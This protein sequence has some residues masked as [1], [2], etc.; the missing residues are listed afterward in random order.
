MPTGTNL[1]VG[2]KISVLSSSMILPS[3][4][5]LN[6]I[7]LYAVIQVTVPYLDRVIISRFTT[8]AMLIITVM[9]TQITLTLCLRMLTGS[10]LSFRVSRLSRVVRL[11]HI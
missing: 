8:I 1:T 5:S 11:K 9:L 2:N 3:I 7:T 10:P 4:Q 6:Q